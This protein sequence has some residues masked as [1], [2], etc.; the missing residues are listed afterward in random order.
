MRL[1]KP[2]GT[3][4]LLCRYDYRLK[5]QNANA[6]IARLAIHDQDAVILPERAI[7]GR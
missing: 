1:M 2:I 3:V 7:A 5:L 6:C 4:I